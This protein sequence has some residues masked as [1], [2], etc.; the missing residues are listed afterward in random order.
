ML[1]DSD[2]PNEPPLL[3]E[4]IGQNPW[5]TV[6]RFAEREALV[7]P[8]Q[9]YRATYRELW[10]Q[11]DIAARALLANHV[12][13]GDRVVVCAPERYEWVVMQFATARAGAI[14]VDLNS[15]ETP[16]ELDYALSDAR[17][18][19][20]MTLESGRGGCRPELPEPIVLEREWDTFLAQGA[21]IGE[22]ALTDREAALQPLDPIYIRYAPTACGPPDKAT[23]SHRDVLDNG[24]RVAHNLRS[25]A[26]AAERCPALYG[27][28]SPPRTVL[29]SRP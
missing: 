29:G 24:R 9:R 14:L 22:L 13:K 27:M 18:S 6:E 12:R 5:R 4:T 7:V 17:V 15:A 25:T 21:C 28:S 8:R 2:G 19:L 11:A 16:A 26:I 10:D 3:E 20:F 23:L 1:S